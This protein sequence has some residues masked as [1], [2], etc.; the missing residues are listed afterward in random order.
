M[1]GSINPRSTIGNVLDQQTERFGDRD[2]FVHV[3]T[4]DRYTYSQFR[5]EV[6]RVA[7]GFMAL[8]IQQGQHVAVWAT[9]YTEWVLCQFATAKIG[10]VQVN[11]N[12][13]YRTRELAYL[14][15]Q[16]EA[17]ALVMIGRFRAPALTGRSSELRGN[18]ERGGS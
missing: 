18:G 14:L 2:A 15:E 1:T 10:A 16:S 8:G 6:D 7:R 3:E 12:P 5:A 4:G 17:S 13:A 11:V 9:N